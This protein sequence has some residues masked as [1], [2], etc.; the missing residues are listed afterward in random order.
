MR[1]RKLAIA[2]AAFLTATIISP[3]ASWSQQLADHYTLRVFAKH[4][5]KLELRYFWTKTE[6]SISPL[7]W[8]P[9]RREEEYTGRTTKTAS[10]HCRSSAWALDVKGEAVL[11][12]AAHCLGLNLSVPGQINNEKLQ[13]DGTIKTTQKYL[14]DDDCKPLT[15]T[16]EVVFGGLAF[17]E[18][19]IGTVSKDGGNTADDILDIAFVKPDDKAVFSDLRLLK[20][21]T[22]TLSVQDKVMVFGFPS[23]L[24]QQAKEVLVADVARDH[25]YCVLNEALDD[26]YSGGVV[27]NK[28]NEAVGVITNISKGQTTVLL[29]TSNVLDKIRWHVSTAMLNKK[30]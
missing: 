6:W 1:I 25:G 9:F 18:K 2:A 26:G 11:V 12:T 20:P 13:D 4:T 28:D 16:T 14:I 8:P 3:M 30:F 21:A 24:S 10:M 22:K 7:H 15:R 27:V 19:E 17:R 23:T 29:L 5:Y